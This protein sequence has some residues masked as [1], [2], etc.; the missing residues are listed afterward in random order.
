MVIRRRALQRA[1]SP[2][3]LAEAILDQVPD[4]S[5]PIPIGAISRA[6]GIE[7]I[8]FVRTYG[9]E[10]CLIADCN[11]PGGMIVANGTSHLVRRRFTVAHELGHFLLEH[12]QE[13]PTELSRLSSD[14]TVYRST[15]SVNE[16]KEANRF[17]ASLL[18]PS[19]FVPRNLLESNEADIAVILRLAKRF[20]TSKQ[21]TAS[22]LCSLVKARVA[23]VFSRNGR[24]RYARRSAGFPF[25]ALKSGQ[26]LCDRT[27]TAQFDGQ[28]GECSGV[29]EIDGFAWFQSE[30]YQ[31]VKVLEQ[32]LVQADGYRL[33]LLRLNKHGYILGRN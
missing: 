17:A 22:R 6:L 24:F 29:V 18:I 8:A 25:I 13:N 23:V 20:Q 9:F 15:Y 26:A 3:D 10:G 7:K 33:T 21:A 31:T 30:R 12:H 19:R 1:S 11:K 14:T 28:S 5:V 27:Q 4:V 16:E 32:V 2:E